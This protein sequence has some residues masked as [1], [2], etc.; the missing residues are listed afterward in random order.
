MVYDER[1]GNF[2]RRNGVDWRNAYDGGVA[3]TNM[4]V[5]HVSARDA[6]AY[7]E[8]LATS[9][10]HRYHVPSEAQFEYALRAGGQGRF[11]LGEGAPPANAGNVTGSGD[12]SP[13]GRGWHNAFADCT[14][15]LWGRSEWHT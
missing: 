6:D 8:W 1:S 10:G 11:P 9:S 2:V 4:P 3:A 7:A 13:S 14:D 12:K 15:G 5:L